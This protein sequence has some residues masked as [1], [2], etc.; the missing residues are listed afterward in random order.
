[1]RIRIDAGGDRQLYKDRAAR[2]APAPALPERPLTAISAAMARRSDAH[3]RR[4]LPGPH[5]CGGGRKRRLREPP[6]ARPQTVSD[7]PRT[8]A[9]DRLFERRAAT[10]ARRRRAMLT[11]VETVTNADPV[12]ESRRRSWTSPHRQPPVNRSMLRLLQDQAVGD[13]TVTARGT[14]PRRTPRCTPSVRAAVR[15]HYDDLEARSTMGGRSSPMASARPPRRPLRPVV[16]AARARHPVCSR[17]V[18]GSKVGA[19]AG[20][21]VGRL[22]LPGVSLRTSGLEVGACR[23]RV[24]KLPVA[25]RDWSTAPCSPAT[26]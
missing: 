8:P 25:S 24:I 13:T 10:L 3:D 15:S 20:A 11:A 4:D 9:L 21:V 2:R 22:C 12:W 6:H 23:T 26:G 16:R 18:G 17:S 19:R 14:T 1:M 7:H 5:P